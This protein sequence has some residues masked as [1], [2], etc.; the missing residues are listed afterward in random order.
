[1]NFV[2]PNWEGVPSHIK[3]I[4]TTRQGG[5]S[6]GC[7]Q[8]LNLGAHVGD[9]KNTVLKNRQYLVDVLNLPSSPT[10]LEQ[11]H[12]INVIQLPLKGTVKNTDGVMTTETNIVCSVMTADCLPI[13]LANKSGQC[14][15][16]I[17]AGWRGLADGILDRAISHFIDSCPSGHKIAASDIIAW[18]GPSISVEHFEVGQ[19]VYEVFCLK[20]EDAKRAFRSTVKKNKWL[21]DLPLLA[22]QKLSTLGVQNVYLSEMCTYKHE[23]EFYSYRRNGTTGRQATLIWMEN[24]EK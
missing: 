5:F 15:A 10:W 14:I 6:L 19:D 3:A 23:Q 7:Y 24:V 16:A 17:H 9:D 21:A 1:M 13:L 11:T 12:S 20:N 22:K 4:S 18:V 2:V 8:G